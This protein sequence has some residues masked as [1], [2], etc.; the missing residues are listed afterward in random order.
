MGDPACP[1]CGSEDVD[2]S[3]KDQKYGCYACGKMFDGAPPTHLRE[4]MYDDRTK[5]TCGCVTWKEG[6]T[7][8]INPCSK[9]CVVYKAVIEASNKRGNPVIER[10][11]S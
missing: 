6:T 10:K 8:Y 11:L 3:R 7:F 9:D 5:W 4:C 1:H 2:W